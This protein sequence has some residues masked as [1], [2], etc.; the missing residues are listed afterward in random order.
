MAIERFA[1]RGE[2]RINGLRRTLLGG[3]VTLGA[4]SAFATATLTLDIA[5]GRP[6][7]GDRVTVLGGTG[8]VPEL[9]FTG[10]IDQGG[11]TL[12]PNE[13]EVRCTHI[14]ARLAAPI[15]EPPTVVSG[16]AEREPVVAY[17]AQTAGAIIADLCARY[18]VPV[19]DLADSGKTWGN[20][21][22]IGLMPGDDGWGLAQ[23][24]D[25]AEGYRTFGAEDGTARRIPWTG[26]PGA[27]NRTYTEGVD[28]YAASIEEDRTGTHNRI[29]ATGL[30]QTGTTGV[31]FTPAATLSA[32]SA[33]V[34]TPP[35]YRAWS[36]SSELFE[37]EADCSAYA[38]RKLGELNRLRGELPVELAV[39]DATLR[40]GM[41]VAVVS[42]RL[43]VRAGARFL[44]EEV[45]HDFGA[46]LNTSAVL[47]LAS[48]GSGWSANQG[49]IALVAVTALAER[50]ADGSDLT[51]FAL[52]G[53]DSYDPELGKAGIVSYAWT[54]TPTAPTVLPGS[55]GKQATVR[56]VGPVPAGAT[57][58]LTVTDDLGKAGRR[59]I[60]LDAP[61]TVVN[62]RDIVAAVGA[63]LIVSRDGQRT[64]VEIKVGAAAIA[65]VGVTEF[66]AA[67]YGLAWDAS[68]NLY[69]F[70]A[71]NTATL[72][73]SAKG[74]TAAS[75]A[76]TGADPETPSGRC[77]AGSSDGRVWFSADDGAGWVA[78]SPA[79]N[80]GRVRHIQESPFQDGDIELA[81]GHVSYRSFDQGGNWA[82]QYTHT[83][84]ALTANRIAAGH[85]QSWIGYGGGATVT[86]EASRLIE[87]DGKAAL[88][89]PTAAKP[90][91][92]VGLTLA[93]ERPYL[94]L[95]DTDSAGV[96]RA[97]GA[98]SDA[99]GTL[100]ALTYDNVA[101]GP[102]RHMVRDGRFPGLLYI[103]AQKQLAKSVDGL[104]S[105]LAMRTLPTGQE[106]HMIGYGAMRL[107]APPPPAS[108]DL[109]LSGSEVTSGAHAIVRLAASGW[110]VV[111]PH[112]DTATAGQRP[113]WRLG[114]T[115][116]TAVRTA[117]G[118]GA[119]TATNAWR[120]TD[121][122]ATW[123]A[124]GAGGVVD[125][126]RGADGTL[127]ALV[128]ETTGGGRYIKRSTDNGAT[129]ATVL[130]VPGAPF[131]RRLD[132]HPTDPAVHAVLRDG[133]VDLTTNTF[134]TIAR[135]YDYPN[136]AATPFAQALDWL[137]DGAGVII[138]HE[139]GAPFRVPYPGWASNAATGVGTTAIT[140]LVR[141][142]GT[143]HLLAGNGLHR[144]NDGL[145]WEKVFA[146]PPPNGIQTN[147]RGYAGH[148]AAT[149][150]VGLAATPNTAPYAPGAS[151]V[152][153]RRVDGGAWENLT[154]GMIAALGQKLY[155]PHVEGLVGG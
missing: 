127:W 23:R 21:E 110:S 47:L 70:L 74:I 149:E 133:I 113:L 126:S 123:V 67:T 83:N 59:T 3:T 17:T 124:L 102:P 151:W 121:N 91:N 39:G 41:A 40:P 107:V 25:E 147:V 141:G 100:A 28:L 11:V 106:G 56:F 44:V 89:W 130:D 118:G 136:S 68:G 22:P 144:S 49:P 80:G 63:A 117:D 111:A 115:L 98:A 20:L 96:G 57:A 101:H 128:A 78:K 155:V 148:P 105:T 122:G 146:V 119:A 92:V 6:A 140:G 116:F 2:V 152:V 153:A 5:E 7:P 86:G 50:L 37:T 137:P 16:Q 94:Y 31:D 79:P 26:T 36:Y 142:G 53:A 27:V 76:L 93:V 35:T 24:L 87:R 55:G 85:G 42:A 48:A 1:P 45:R 65:A 109:L 72:V 9:L 90:A 135:S 132:S 15:A 66:A 150:Y 69:K 154:D 30:P 19:G 143:A 73:L 95:L 145:A 61:G 62:T 13:I 58:T 112:P 10:E 46:G 52:D 34:P 82:A 33:W 75:I 12:A 131:I 4:R 114:A 97:W 32:P 104:Q 84:A 54:G 71:D 138:G 38:A 8:Y 139:G 103:A 108:G 64:W 99:S 29:T 43:D 134:G 14:L 60:A 81:A 129:W 125:L 18:G 77:W 120:S 88:D 51:E